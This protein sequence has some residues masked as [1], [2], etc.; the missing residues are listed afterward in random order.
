MWMVSGAD[1]VWIH[2]HMVHVDPPLPSFSFDGL[3]ETHTGR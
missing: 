3:E 2:E 1:V